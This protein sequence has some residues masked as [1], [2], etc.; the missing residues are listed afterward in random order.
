MVG[1]AH[2]VILRAMAGRGVD[3][4]G[5]LFKRDV[6]AQNSQGIALQERVAEDS[7]LKL[8]AGERGEQL[9]FLPIAGFGRGVY[10]ILGDEIDNAV[11]FN[12][13]VGESRVITDGEIR[14]NGPGRGGPDE[15]K[16][17]FA[18]QGRID[19]LGG[20]G[21][22]E[23][24]PNGRAGMVFVLDFGLGQRRAVMDA[25]VDRLQS[26]V[27]EA[28]VQKID[29]R[30]GDDGF[31]LGAHREVRIMPTAEDAQADEVPA[32]QV[33][34]LFGVFSARRADLTDGHVGFFRAQFVVDFVLD[35]Q[36]VTVPAW[37]VRGIEP[38]HGFQLDDKVL[39]D[40][41]EGGTQMNIPV[42][43]GRAVVKNVHRPALAGGANAFVE[44]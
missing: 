41:V 43:V 39:Q 26:F 40:L 18:G 35:R 14:R 44:I 10:Q 11:I 7:L 17:A 2:Q 22:G 33:D 20:R 8:F 16:D 19:G 3:G 37:D 27:N 30:L 13:R 15:A 9:Q 21:Q 5:A 31:V 25:P 32:L 38:L 34:V 36:A 12:R 28:L 24:H 23:F 42:G 29:E 6:I 1:V 4:S